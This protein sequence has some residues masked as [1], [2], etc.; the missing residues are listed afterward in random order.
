MGMPDDVIKQV[1]KYF[2]ALSDPM[3]I[4]ILSAVR[5]A[6]HSISELAALVGGGHA[7][8]S[9]H[10]KILVDAGIVN[11]SISGTKTMISIADQHSFELCTQVCDVLA[12]HLEQ[13]AKKAIALQA[14]IKNTV[15]M[16]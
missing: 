10:T 6:P 8:V 13:D 2:R 14:A 5:E 12:K 7:N 4:G 11:R 16:F 15:K 3:R 9:K 1:A